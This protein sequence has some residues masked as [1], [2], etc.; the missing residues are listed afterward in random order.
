MK[1]MDHWIQTADRIIKEE[2]ESFTFCCCKKLLINPPHAGSDTWYKN[3]KSASPAEWDYT[4]FT[5]T[6]IKKKFGGKGKINKI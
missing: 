2:E 3:P 6:S 1:Y 4:Y 5:L